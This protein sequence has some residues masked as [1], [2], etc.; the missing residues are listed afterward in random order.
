MLSTIEKLLFLKE[1]ELFQSLSHEDLAQVAQIAL[2]IE[3]EAGEVIIVEGDIGDALFL[4]LDGKVRVHKGDQTLTTLGEKEPIGEMGILDSAPRS[5]SVTA[6]VDLRMLKI[7]RDDF[8][9]LM[10]DRLEIAQGIIKVLLTRLR[11]LSAK[12]VAQNVKDNNKTPAQEQNPT[13]TRTSAPAQGPALPRTSAPA[14]G[15][16]LPRTS[17][18]AQGPAL[19]RTSAPAQGPALPRTSAPAQGPALPRTSAPAQG[20]AL[21]RTSAPA[22]GPALPR[23]SAPAQ[24]PALPRTSAPAQGSGLSQAP[25]SSPASSSASSSASSPA[26]KREEPP[27]I[28]EANSGSWESS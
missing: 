26:G 14:Q 15:P 13:P 5:A 8:H 18:P 1:I 27:V 24:G 16:A 10:A 19:P 11:R 23:T 12:S 4:L 22:Q 17:A 25:A 9:E 28:S 20:P 21:P 6:M 2:E 7:E 3:I